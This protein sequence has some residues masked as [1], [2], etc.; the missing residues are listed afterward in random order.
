MIQNG[1]C[2]YLDIRKQNLGSS[3]FCEGG[4]II[5]KPRGITQTCKNGVMQISFH[6]ELVLFIY[7]FILFIFLNLFIYIFNQSLKIT[8]IFIDPF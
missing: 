2:L 1:T 3:I 8:G 7:L 5:L 6:C 4:V